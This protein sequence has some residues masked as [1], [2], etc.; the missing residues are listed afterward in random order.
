MSM[1]AWLHKNVTILALKSCFQ[2]SLC[3]AE[4]LG[5]LSINSVDVPLYIGLRPHH[6]LH[7]LLDSKWVDWG[8]FGKLPSVKSDMMLQ[9]CPRDALLQNIDTP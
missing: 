2:Q 7:D 3:W 8:K 6:A 4:I 9:L 5:S 1:N